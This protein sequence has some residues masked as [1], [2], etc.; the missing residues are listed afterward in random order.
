MTDEMRIIDLRM[1]FKN[2]DH[3]ILAGFDKD[4]MT[5]IKV[6]YLKDGTSRHM[7][8]MVIDGVIKSIPITGSPADFIGRRK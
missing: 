3:M 2:E 4:E 7:N 6:H 8:F 1:I 5:E